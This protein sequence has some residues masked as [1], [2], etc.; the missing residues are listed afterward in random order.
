VLFVALRALFVRA[1]G[2][3]WLFV[4]LRAC[5]ALFWCTVALF[6]C[7]VHCIGAMFHVEQYKSGNFGACAA[8]RVSLRVSLRAALRAALRVAL[9]VLHCF[10]ACC[11]V[12][13]RCSTWNSTKIGNFCAFALYWCV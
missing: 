3:S 11:T 6:W 7:V 2:S 4:A 5:A 10:G 12:L 1:C 8:L 9:R 13:V